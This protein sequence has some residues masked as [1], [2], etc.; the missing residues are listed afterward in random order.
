MLIMVYY[1]TNYGKAWFMEM[2]IIVV[3]IIIIIVRIMARFFTLW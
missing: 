2:M 1:E 3:F